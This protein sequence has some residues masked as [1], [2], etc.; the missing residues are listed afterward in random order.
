MGLAGMRAPRS[1]A[2]SLSG[3]QP[4]ARP[5]KAPIGGMNLPTQAANLPQPIMPKI[6]RQPIQQPVV[7]PVVQTP[8]TLTPVVEP[9]A[10]KLVRAPVISPPTVATVQEPVLEPAT[11]V[12]PVESQ[13][14]IEDVKPEIV[15]DEIVPELESMDEVLDEALDAA[16]EDEMNQVQETV[17]LTPIKTLK[18]VEEIKTAVLKPVTVK[19]LTPVKRRGPPPSSQP[20]VKPD[21]EGQK[22]ATA[23]LKPITKLTP[24]SSPN[25]KLNIISEEEEN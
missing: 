25:T 6:V 13:L 10:E 2:K 8:E 23:S 19:T 5:V 1:T 4:I 14:E 16:M 21:G 7:Q 24:V 22:E 17:M 12:I 3:A 9:I 20:G 18:V 15:T 11:T